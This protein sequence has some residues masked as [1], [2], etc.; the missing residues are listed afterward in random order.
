MFILKAGELFLV[1]IAI[2]CRCAPKANEQTI[3]VLLKFAPE[4]VRLEHVDLIVRLEDVTQADTEQEDDLPEAVK[5]NTAIGGRNGRDRLLKLKNIP[6]D[7]QRIYNV[8]L[9]VDVD[10]DG[11]L[12]NGDYV[13]QER[14]S[15]RGD[16]VPKNRNRENEVVVDIRPDSLRKE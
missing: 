6:I 9:I 4:V 16:S 2:Q 12:S 5:E 14:F 1:F 7:E 13:T 11:T 10:R 8:R 3:R 15:F